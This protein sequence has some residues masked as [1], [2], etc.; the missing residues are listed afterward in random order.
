MTTIDLPE[1]DLI[2]VPLSPH[3]RDV[4]GPAGKVGEETGRLALGLP[5]LTPL[6]LETI[7]EEARA[8]LRSRSNSRF[9]MLTLT[10]SF[11]SDEDNP[12]ES[13]W[14]DVK[15]SCPRS[16]GPAAP[17]AWSMRP[18]SE[19]DVSTVVRKVSIDAS[20]KL[21]MPGIPVEAGPHAGR[22][23]NETFNRQIIKVEALREGTS[24]PRWE[25]FP[26]ETTEIRGVHR[27]CMIIDIP[28]TETGLAEVSLGATI[29]IRRMKIFRYSAAL[30]DVPQVARVELPP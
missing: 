29:R 8:F 7:D 18:R 12:F 24:D 28:V 9:T 30:T 6:T 27:L 19:A 1:P 4:L 17:V 13:A 20:L 11:A 23:K 16:L 22:E 14:V 5:V 3:R 21:S 2:A 15:I 10:T 26:T 25:F